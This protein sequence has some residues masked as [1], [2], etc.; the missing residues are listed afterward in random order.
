MTKKTIKLLLFENDA[1]FR[2]KTLTSCKQ[3][4]IYCE[5]MLNEAIIKAHDMSCERTSANEASYRLD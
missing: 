3:T 1:C 2:D 5:F 4:I